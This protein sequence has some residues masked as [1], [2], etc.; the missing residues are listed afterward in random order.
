MEVKLKDLYQKKNT[1]EFTIDRIKQDI[2]EL[3]TKLTNEEKSLASDKQIQALSEKDLSA[4][5]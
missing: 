5:N 1:A 3:S 4:R 2:T